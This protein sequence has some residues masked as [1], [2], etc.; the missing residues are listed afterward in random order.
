MRG[1]LLVA[2]VL[3]GCGSPA[4]SSDASVTVFA[5]ASLTDAFEE[6]AADYTDESG[7]EVI[8]SFDSSSA[9]RSQIEEGAPAD[10]FASADLVNAQALVDA[11]LTDGDSRVFAGNGLAVVVPLGNPAGIDRWTT[12]P[13]S[14]LRII[15]AGEDVPITRYAVEL[16]DHLAAHP[17]APGGFADAYAANIVTRED[18]VRAVLAKIEVGEGDAAIV[19]E[20]DAAS[21][22]EVTRLAIP[23]EANVVAAYALVTIDEAG[24]GATEFVTW[25][26]GE[27]AQAILAA[28]GFRAPSGE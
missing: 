2:L 4:G 1:V 8:L 21:S 18:N 24:P 15:A 3:A 7:V 9:L 14:G 13:T 10:V 27:R 16:V 6:L 28:H 26:L 17:D 12:L 11:G 22:D 19:Y 25:L 5:A 23:E 20:T